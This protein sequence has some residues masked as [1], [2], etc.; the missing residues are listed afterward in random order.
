MFRRII[1]A[2]HRLLGHFRNTPEDAYIPKVAPSADEAILPIDPEEYTIYPH[3]LK[4]KMDMGRDFILLDVRDEWEFQVV[5]LDGAVSIPLGE[6][7]RRFGELSPGDE[8]IVYCHKG[9]RSLDAAYLL[10]QLGFNSTLSLVGGIDKWA[11]E[12]DQ[13][14][15]RY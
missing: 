1:E 13:D 9:M 4:H 14:I 10:Q 11:C 7:P 12:I 6:L 5:H 3:E 2:L 15:Q 8:I